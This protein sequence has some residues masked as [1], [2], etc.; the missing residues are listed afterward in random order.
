MKTVEVSDSTYDEIKKYLEGHKFYRKE[1]T[2][3]E[4]IDCILAMG[5]F[6][7]RNDGFDG[8]AHPQKPGDFGINC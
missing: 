2:I 1:Y 4:Y 6:A 3:D 7:Y 5:W 8:S